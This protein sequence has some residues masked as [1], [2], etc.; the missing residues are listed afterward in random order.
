MCSFGKGECCKSKTG[1]SASSW[2]Q[3]KCWKCYYFFLPISEPL[4][5]WTGHIKLVGA[6]RERVW[7]TGEGTPLLLLH[8]SPTPVSP[9]STPPHLATW[10]STSVPTY[11]FGRLLPTWLHGH[12]PLLLPPSPFMCWQVQSQASKEKLETAGERG[13]GGWGAGSIAGGVTEEKVGNEVRASPRPMQPMWS[14][15]DP[16]LVG[17]LQYHL[18]SAG[19][20]KLL[21]TPVVRQEGPPSYFYFGLHKR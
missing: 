8:K 9:S 20:A 19:V 14:H 21:L 11:F 6:G 18:P 4:C 3:E 10:V 2:P 13:C 5:L 7:W 1:F 15:W 12:L 16:H 17:A